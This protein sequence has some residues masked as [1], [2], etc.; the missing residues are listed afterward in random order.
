[1]DRRNEWADR[2]VVTARYD[3]GNG[4]P[5]QRKWRDPNEWDVR[6]VIDALQGA[7]LV[8]CELPHDVVV[9]VTE[10]GSAYYGP[11]AYAPGTAAPARWC[12]PGR[13]W[14]ET[15]AAVERALTPKS[16]DG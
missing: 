4:P 9:T 10:R 8:P 6:Q 1:M 11:P 2:I 5:S 12:L 7:S 14:D 16:D 3:A 15:V 13:S